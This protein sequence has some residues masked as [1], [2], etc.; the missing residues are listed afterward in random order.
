MRDRV[1]RGGNGTA[2][3]E[4]PGLSLQ[5]CGGTDTSHVSTGVR[6]DLRDTGAKPCH[7]ASLEQE[8]AGERGDRH[9][10]ARRS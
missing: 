8:C 2:Q 4:A 6:L 9:K 10:S 1:E 5:G 3:W 7:V